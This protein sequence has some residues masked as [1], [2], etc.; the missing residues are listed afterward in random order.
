LPASET[1]EVRDKNS[2]R[3]QLLKE[4]TEMAEILLESGL[5]GDHL[6][7]R[8]N[9]PG[10]NELDNIA[11]RESSQYPRISG[12]PSQ[13]PSNT[14]IWDGTIVNPDTNLSTERENQDLHT[15]F[16]FSSG[17]S[18]PL[19]ADLLNNSIG[20][21]STLENNITTFSSESDPHW[22]HPFE[23]NAFSFPN[24]LDFNVNDLDL[25]ITDS[26]SG[27]DFH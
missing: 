27:W 23:S 21:P 26:D 5:S 11:D 7:D 22:F 6:K 16:T 19:M 20:E 12:S 13:F 3:K 10:P 2:K 8:M 9:H 17:L 15:A 4:I 24:D 14:S 1:K 25:R 18:D